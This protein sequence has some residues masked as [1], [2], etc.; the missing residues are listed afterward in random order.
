MTRYN[1]PLPHNQVPP[2]QGRPA[3]HAA[4]AQHGGHLPYGAQERPAWPQDAH[5]QI[6]AAAYPDQGYPAEQRAAPGHDPYAALRPDGYGYAQQPQTAHADPFAHAG[7]NAPQGFG[8]RPPQNHHQQQHQPQPQPPAYDAYGAADDRFGAGA[9]APAPQLGNGQSASDFANSPAAAFGAAASAFAAQHA[10]PQQPYAAQAAGRGYDMPAPLAQPQHVQPSA[11]DSLAVPQA[12]AAHGVADT[13]GNQGL[14]LDPQDY[15]H[16][17]GYGDPSLGGQADHQWGAEAY[18]QP[19]QHGDPN[20]AYM[21]AHQGQ[22]SF[23][24]SYA[25][26]DVH[27]EDEPQQGRS[28][29]KIAVMFGCMAVIGT[30]MA[31]SYDSLMGGGGG[32]P[33][34]VVKGAEGPS[35]VKPSDPGGKQFAHTDS[36]IMGRLGEGGSQQAADPA[37]VRKVPVVDVGPDGSIRPP[38]SS[39]DETRAVVAVPGLTV[40]DG[41]GGPSPNRPN[42]PGAQR[43]KNIPPG[44]APPVQMVTG[45][46]NA[47][48]VVVAPPTQQAKSLAAKAGPDEAMAMP[49]KAAMA[50]PK[51]ERPAPVAKKERVAAVDPSPAPRASGGAGYVAVLA[52]VPASDSSRI[53]ALTQF[54]DMQQKYGAILGNKTPDI[55]EANLGEKGTYHRLLVGPPSSRDSAN[56]VCSQLKAQGFSGCWVTAY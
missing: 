36:K 54:A 37:G 33:T 44:Q 48:P 6:P 40:I 27:Y 56:S 30:V 16:G 7:Y 31:V 51:A 28:W 18:G 21:A 4:P 53:N 38:S 2:T 13:W 17:H 25:D 55:R 34:P 46:N 14:A 52:S 9:F 35:K 26:D 15:Q 1:N 39:Q 43:Q 11:Y 20:G 50:P 5:Q 3:Q 41:L 47:Q 45:S 24:Q 22:A 49:T 10:P 19:Q 29:K 8:A 12:H 42:A 32:G 23:D